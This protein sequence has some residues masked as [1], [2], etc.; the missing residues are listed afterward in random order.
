MKVMLGKR[1]I[2]FL[3]RLGRC[4]SLSSQLVVLR[5]AAS[6]GILAGEKVPYN[7]L[8]EDFVTYAE[9]DDLTVFF[10]IF[11]HNGEAANMTEAARTFGRYC[12]RGLDI[13]EEFLDR[14]ELD[15]STLD[16]IL[17]KV[18]EYVSARGI[19]EE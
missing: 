17:V 15:D 19:E 14:G 11:N 4:A 12:G 2:R 5:T 10:L 6:V 3:G 1:H 9:V 16:D 8:T 13:M 18:G 7:E